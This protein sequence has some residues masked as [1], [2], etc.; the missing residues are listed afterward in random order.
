MQD[1][2]PTSR[3]LTDAGSTA[4]KTRSTR[5]RPNRASFTNRSCTASF[6]KMP[7]QKRTRSASESSLTAEEVVNSNSAVYLD[8][9]IDVA[10]KQATYLPSGVDSSA[11]AASFARRFATSLTRE[12]T[13]FDFGPAGGVLE[14]S[15]HLARQLFAN[16]T[17]FQIQAGGIARGQPHG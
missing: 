7:E 5:D 12:F 9:G 6:G 14:I 1:P 8:R 3:I 16:K 4:G 2:A 15:T 10:P 11:M 17:G 13:V